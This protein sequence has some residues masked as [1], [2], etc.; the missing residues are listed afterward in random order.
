MEPLLLFLGTSLTAGYGVEDAAAFPGR[1][2][3]RIDSAGWP[4]TVET[5]G[6]G[7]AMASGGAG[8]LSDVPLP[9]V[10]VLVVELGVNDALHG[11]SVPV[12]RG[13][14]EAVVRAARVRWPRVRILFAA[15]RA[16]PMRSPEYRRE[17]RRMY[18]RLAKFEGTALAGNI[19]AGVVGRDDMTLYDGV[20]PNA[21]G[22]AR[23]ARNL[24]P[25][26]C[27]L[28]RRASR[29]DRRESMSPG[30]P[31]D[32]SLGTG[33]SGCPPSPATGSS[34]ATGANPCGSRKPEPKP[35]EGA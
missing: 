13:H 6:H 24:W 4:F 25:S 26:L 22:H 18:R 34:G 16:P 9:Q 28:L 7:G 15:V 35:G 27:P 10:D 2:E 20:H 33:R 17:F 8:R 3:S 23:I 1:I 19:L 5:A 31:P 21:K 30:L 14:L 11:V 29:G 32:A 12:V